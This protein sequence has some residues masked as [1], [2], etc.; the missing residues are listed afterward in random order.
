MLPAGNVA[1]TL[2]RS[3]TS[4]VA[5][6]SPRTMMHNHLAVADSSDIHTLPAGV[7]SNEQRGDLGFVV[8][9]EYGGGRPIHLHSLLWREADLVAAAVTFLQLFQQMYPFLLK[10]PD[11]W[12]W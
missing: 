4:P 12:R 3:W 1:T 5:A 10:M 8:L 11:I 2:A 6:S 9:A 7:R